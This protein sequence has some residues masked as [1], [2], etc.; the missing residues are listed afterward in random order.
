VSKTSRSNFATSG[1]WHRPDAAA[2]FNVLRLV[3]DDTAALRFGSVPFRGQ[4]Q[5]ATVD[6]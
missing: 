3:E 4:C 1:R 5:D 2:H 6:A